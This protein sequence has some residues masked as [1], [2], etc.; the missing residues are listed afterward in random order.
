MVVDYS[1]KG[2]GTRGTVYADAETTVLINN[3]LLVFTLTKIFVGRCQYFIVSWVDDGMSFF[4]CIIYECTD[5]IVLGQSDG[6]KMLMVRRSF[7]LRKTIVNQ[8]IT[9]T[10]LPNV[11]FH[12]RDPFT[13]MRTTM[14]RRIRNQSRS[15]A[16]SLWTAGFLI[17][18]FANSPKMF[19]A[20]NMKNFSQPETHQLPRNFMVFTLHIVTESKY[21]CISRQIQN[22]WHSI[23][24]HYY[25]IAKSW[26]RQS[27]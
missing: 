3:A 5:A 26:K 24:Q 20:K 14:K 27:G 23:R 22:N 12:H 17:N 9:T 16:F 7:P 2:I 8:H 15:N 11:H 21:Q 4:T 1:N 13:R 19:D 10:Y 25:I 18:L 6:E